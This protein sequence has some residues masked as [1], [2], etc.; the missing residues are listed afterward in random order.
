M[1]NIIFVF[2]FN[3]IVKYSI[4]DDDVELLNVPVPT[5]LNAA[6]LLKSK[7]LNS[8]FIFLE[9]SVLSNVFSNFGNLLLKFSVC[10]A[11]ALST[12]WNA[13]PILC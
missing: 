9:T 11:S 4:V 2:L 10:V 7:S 5:N 13:P 6:M 3:L 12:A 1:F 8:T